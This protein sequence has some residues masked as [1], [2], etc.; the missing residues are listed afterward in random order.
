MCEVCMRIERIQQ[1][2]NPCFVMAL[3]TGYVVFGDFQRFKGYTLF[4]AKNHVR[5]VYHLAP[6]IR[7]QHLLEMSIVAEA[8]DRVFKPE[9]MNYESLGNGIAH[10]HWHFYPRYKNDS[11]IKGPVWWIGKEELYHKDYRV[12]EAFL[13]EYIPKLQ[14]EITQLIEQN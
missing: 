4:L 10:L 12:T 1:G 13:T 6:A 8:V 5:E 11:P 7:Q 2:E 3:E 14:K 9:K